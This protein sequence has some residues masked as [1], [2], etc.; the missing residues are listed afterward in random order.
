MALHRMLDVEIGVADPATLDA[1][2]QEIGFVGGDGLWGA[3]DQPGQIRIVEAPYRQ[4]RK[5]RLGCEDEAD[6]DAIGVT[7]LGHK[8][9]LMLAAKRYV[10]GDETPAPTA[11]KIAKPLPAYE[12]WSAEGPGAL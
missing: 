6:L 5:V 8:K 2:Y 3:A 9:R 12:N 4:L 7:L 10:K 1:F 11:L